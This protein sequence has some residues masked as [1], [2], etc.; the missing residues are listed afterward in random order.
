VA[1]LCGGLQECRQGRSGVEKST[2]LLPEG[3][4]QIDVDRLSWPYVGGRSVMKLVAYAYWFPNGCLHFNVALGGLKFKC[5]V[6]T[7]QNVQKHQLKRK[8][9]ILIFLLRSPGNTVAEYERVQ[10]TAFSMPVYLFVCLC[11]CLFVCPLACLNNH[12]HKCEVIACLSS[13]T[14]FEFMNC[15]N[16]YCNYGK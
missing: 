10:R 12:R 1:V 6:N 9:I 16:V 4:P 5:T 13:Q 14:Q 15:Y 8:K 11:V 3:I 7:T 2:S